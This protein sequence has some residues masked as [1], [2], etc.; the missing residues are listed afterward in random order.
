MDSHLIF[1]VPYEKAAA[2]HENQLTRALLVVLRYSPMAHQAWLRMVAPEHPLHN[3]SKA[4]FATQRQ[5]VLGI[6]SEV[7]EGEAVLGI[8]VWLA[9][10]PCRLVHLSNLLIGS[11]FLMASSPMGPTLSS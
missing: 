4:E 6:D 7:P 8:S 2:W 3:L 11:K 1:F 5:H 10:T 9:R